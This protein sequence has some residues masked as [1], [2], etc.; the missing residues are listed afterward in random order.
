MYDNTNI[1]NQ[2]N[3]YKTFEQ[4]NED[5]LQPQFSYSVSQQKADQLNKIRNTKESNLAGTNGT[6]LPKPRLNN[7][8]EKL[9]LGEEYRDPNVIEPDYVDEAKAA[10]YRAGRDFGR[11]GRNVT[12]W[13]TN[14]LGMDETTKYLDDIHFKT[15]EEINKV[16]DYDPRYAKQKMDAI[17]DAYDRGDYLGMITSGVAAAPTLLIDSSPDMLMLMSGG[18]SGVVASKA[19][20]YAMLANDAKKALG[21]AKGIKAAYIAK[22]AK[23]ANDL[24][25]VGEVAKA[26]EVLNTAKIERTALDK[27]VVDASTKADMYKA[28]MNA[29][30]DLS[31]GF[32]VGKSTALVG[33]KEASNNAEE[34]YENTGKK[35]STTRALVDALA[36][37]LLLAPEAALF[38]GIVKS[39]A[40]DVG[41]AATGRMLSALKDGNRAGVFKSLW[42]NYKDILAVGGFEAGQE[43]LQQWEGILAKEL[44]TKDKETGNEKTFSDLV[45][46]AGHLKETAVAAAGGFGTAGT[47]RAVPAGVSLGLDVAT[48]TIAKGINVGKNIV[49]KARVKGAMKVLSPEE[50]ARLKAKYESE[51][52][53]VAE[54]I[55]GKEDLINTINNPY[56]TIE[57]LES[58]EDPDLQYIIKHKKAEK[59][60]LDKSLNTIEKAEDDKT[61]EKQLSY[62]QR[63]KYDSAVSEFG[64]NKFEALVKSGRD[65]K[66]IKDEELQPTLED[67]K[68]IATDII[69][70]DIDEAT[71]SYN[72]DDIKPA[73]VAK[74]NEDITAI[75]AKHEANRA[76]DYTYSMIKG[77]YDT[78][79]DATNSVLN[80]INPDTR[81]AIVDSF[82]YAVKTGKD[83]GNYVV[84]SV[85]N[86]D[87]STTRALVD[88]IMD[89]KAKKEL[90]KF[91]YDELDSLEQSL[92]KDHPKAA[93]V[94]RRAKLAKR[95]G[96]KLFNMT[97]NEKSNEDTSIL[98]KAYDMIK[99]G[100]DSNIAMSV[101][102]LVSVT[103]DNLKD[104]EVLAKAEKVVNDLDKKLSV[105]T[106]EEQSVV[107]DA[108][109]KIER[110]KR[111]RELENE[112][113]T[114]EANNDSNVEEGSTTN[115]TLT[116]INRQLLDVENTYE[117]ISD[118][119]EKVS[120][121]NNNIH[122]ILAI[123]RAA[124]KDVDANKLK[125]HVLRVRKLL[126][127]Y[128]AAIGELILQDKE[129]G[130]EQS[131]LNSISNVAKAFIDSTNTSLNDIVGNDTH[132]SSRNNNNNNKSKST[133]NEKEVADT[134]NNVLKEKTIKALSNLANNYAVDEKLSANISKVLDNPNFVKIFKD[135]I[136]NGYSNY[137][138]KENIDK[139]I[140]L[141][142]I[143]GEKHNIDVKSK[144][145]YKLALQIQSEVSN[146]ANTNDSSTTS[147]VDEKSVNNS[148][149]KH[150]TSLGEHLIK[151]IDKL[152]QLE[153]GDSANATKIMQESVKHQVE[154]IDN[155][156]NEIDKL[157]ED[158]SLD[159]TITEIL[160]ALVPLRSYVY[161]KEHLDSVGETKANAD[162]AIVDNLYDRMLEEE[163]VTNDGS[164]VYVE[165]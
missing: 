134:I 128:E 127:K 26:R 114:K 50:R 46:N 89:G 76:K 121:L 48:G 21:T 156:N 163:L 9:L 68:K 93:A 99:K 96:L 66:S 130:V 53:I 106:E 123:I 33:S 95:L 49:G 56:I 152:S 67:K 32:D 140:E 133:A 3:L 136:N 126:S 20:R 43:Y 1:D 157:G 57:D 2:D 146:N 125:D 143:I 75:Q 160:P 147:Q 112:N 129:K 124:S 83:V 102:G 52:K 29:L 54:T 71:K 122:D 15:D 55:K 100:F 40:K 87:E 84:N 35:Y 61:I 79:K 142:N 30:K 119:D 25:K 113:S 65:A 97:D 78:L 74:I 34:Y 150:V 118:L 24:R 37:T 80:Q 81:K 131:K 149:K 154:A 10:F 16:A 162:K 108:K 120:Y 14:K 8:I 98:D 47:A 51:D 165:C 38:K 101:R 148:I 69:S 111:L 132:E 70:K 151:T 7:E 135:S 109:S 138:Y 161:S 18:G 73:L 60:G 86:I 105:L 62:T 139:V 58:I 63:G 39:S 6:E 104:S 13:A 117:S 31:H 158:A 116:D 44:G 85:E 145:I 42:N 19:A 90:F 77:S 28:K 12:S 103:M 72:V 82:N 22:E 110:T 137:V 91:T 153:D 59:V 23:V 141:L 41:D 5:T 164:E 88:D 45:T 144:E 92:Q 107:N 115:S 155:I 27:A 17:G 4:N 159:P 11:L 64:D 94:V 36:N